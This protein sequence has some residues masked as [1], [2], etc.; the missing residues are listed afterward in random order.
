MSY[1]S[2]VRRTILT[3]PDSVR[4]RP[5]DEFLSLLRDEYPVEPEVDRM[6]VRRLGRRDGDIRPSASLE[7]LTQALDALLEVNVP[8]PFAV[9]DQAWFP[10]GAS[11]MQMGFQ[12]HRDEPGKGPTST[13][14]MVR[15]EPPESLNT[16]S[17]LREFQLIR[18]VTGRVPVPE[19]YWVD[20]DAEFFPEPAL[21]YGLVSGVTKPS[22]TDSGRVTGLGTTFGP[23]ERAAL[24]PQFLEHLGLIHTTPLDDVDLS[25]FAR[26]TVGTKE[27]SLWQLNRARRVWEEDRGEALPLM[28][29]ASAWLERNMPTIDTVSLLHGD[30]RTGNFLYDE[31]TMKIT[32]WLDWERGYLGD[33]HRDLAWTMTSTYGQTTPDG[34]FLVAGMMTRDEFLSGYEDAS[35]LSVDEDRLHYFQVLNYYQM[36][37]VGVASA[38]RVMRLGRTHQDVLLPWIEAVVHAVGADLLASLEM[39]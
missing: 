34:T 38:Y 6:L 28:D 25:A 1:E 4:D 18:A 5:N 35:G 11:K 32:A 7:E 31:T 19:L 16:T 20:N 24:G 9:T 21:I 12:L 15:M 30:F 29:V 2:G 37:V 22:Q 39:A 13:P 27:A 3:V 33:R 8:G 36:M 23:Q 10:G 26:P 17:R 14:M